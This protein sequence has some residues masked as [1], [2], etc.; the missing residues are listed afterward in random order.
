[1]KKLLISLIVGCGLCTQTHAEDINPNTA[2]RFIAAYYQ[3]MQKHDL[4]SVSRMIDERVVIKVVWTEANPA[5]SFTF[6][7]A[8]YLQQLKATWHFAS[9]DNYEM[10]NLSASIVNGV[11]VV[12]LQDQQSRVLFGKPTGQLNDLKIGLGGDNSNPRIATI[13]SKTAFL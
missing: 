10:K 7:K 9:K 1:M 5:Q 3:A 12:T 4:A 13:S 8:E 2:A 11:T 6:S